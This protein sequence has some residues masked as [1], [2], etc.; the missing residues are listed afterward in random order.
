VITVLGSVIGPDE[1][2]LAYA[3]RPA[4]SSAGR[5]EDAFTHSHSEKNEGE[6]SDA[7]AYAK[8]ESRQTDESAYSA[9]FAV[10]A[11]ALTDRR[12]IRA[13]ITP[14]RIR[15]AQ[16]AAEEPLAVRVSI[17]STYPASTK[18]AWDAASASIAMRLPRHLRHKDE[19]DW[20]VWQPQFADPEIVWEAVRLWQTRGASGATD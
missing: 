20:W 14:G 9:D 17:N 11:C 5:D 1:R 10:D 13:T 7:F 15:M 16:V 12:I 19:A 6:Q 3:D 8:S 2:L 18:P 4:S